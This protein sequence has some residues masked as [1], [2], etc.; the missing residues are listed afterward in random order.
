MIR[1]GAVIPIFMSLILLSVAAVSDLQFSRI[2]NQW[3]LTGLAAGVLCRILSW[4][5]FGWGGFSLG[6]L[7]PFLICW[8]PF[9]MGAMGAGDVKLL[10]ALGALNGGQDIFWCIFFS[11]LFAAGI[12]LGRLLSLRQ[13]KAS[14]AQ[15]FFYFQ[16]FFSTGKAGFYEG[17]YEK[18]HTIHFAVP[19][20]LGYILWLGVNVCRVLL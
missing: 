11:F 9:R 17:R 16:S 1:I 20:L 15:L 4:T 14:L 12:S 3:I 7:I 10:V 18:G 19:V 6:M 13:F 8:I 2:P 5:S